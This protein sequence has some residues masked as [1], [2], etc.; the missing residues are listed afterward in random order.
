M[1]YPLAVIV[2]HIQNSTL[3]HAPTRFVLHQ[4]ASPNRLIGCVS[5]HFVNT[6]LRVLLFDYT[7]ALHV[8]FDASPYLL[9]GCVQVYS[10]LASQLVLASDAFNPSLI[11]NYYLVRLPRKV[12]QMSNQ[13]NY[14]VS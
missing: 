3:G 10:L 5:I 2:F 4:D 7:P 9:I 12:D 11:Q 13:N 8:F 1:G 6:L 14:F